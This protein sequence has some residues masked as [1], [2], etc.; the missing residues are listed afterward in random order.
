[1]YSLQYYVDSSPTRPIHQPWAPFTSSTGP[2]HLTTAIVAMSFTFSFYI[3][4]VGPI[5][6]P[7]HSW[8]R[9]HQH[10]DKQFPPVRQPYLLRVMGRPLFGPGRTLFLTREKISAASVVASHARE[11]DRD[12]ASCRCSRLSAIPLTGRQTS[13]HPTPMIMAKLWRRRQWARSSRWPSMVNTRAGLL[14]SVLLA[15][16]P[17]LDL[18]DKWRSCGVVHRSSA[19]VRRSLSLC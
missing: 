17:G 15:R 4:S 6:P 5:F 1:M 11:T 16:C 3:F 13:P 12:T 9:R 2:K 10:P 7:P 14:K 19:L 8:K 18:I